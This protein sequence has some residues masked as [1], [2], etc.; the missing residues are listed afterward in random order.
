MMHLGPTL[1]ASQLCALLISMSPIMNAWLVLP[2]LRTLLTMMRQE[3]TLLATRLFALHPNT[4]WIMCV[5]TVLLAPS[6]LTKRMMPLAP[7]PLAKQYPVLKTTLCPIT[8]VLPVLPVL[9][10]PL[11]MMHLVPALL[12]MQ[13]TVL[14]IIMYLVMFVWLVLLVHPTL[15][16]TMR[17][18]ATLLATM[19][20]VLLILRDPVWHRAVFVTLVTTVRSLPAR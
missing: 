14:L 8:V 19:L 15:L 18:E 5:L 4:Y 7:T 12:V 17:R 6:I 9:P 13:P 2:V 11:V 1:L 10:T 3:A 16:M 20:H